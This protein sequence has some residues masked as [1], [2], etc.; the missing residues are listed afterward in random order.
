MNPL[1]QFTKN[2]ILERIALGKSSF[3]DEFILEAINNYNIEGSTKLRAQKFI[4][5]LIPIWTEY[6]KGIF[7]DLF[8]E[9]INLEFSLEAFTI[10][11]AS[12]INH[13][14]QEFLLGY[15]ILMSCCCIKKDYDFKNGRR[16]SHST[17]GE[18][19][20][21]WMAA[22]LF[23]DVGYDI[24]KAP[25]EE[26]YREKRNEFW[27][28]MTKREINT[29][30]LTFNPK[31]D[32]KKI[33]ENHIIKEFNKILGVTEY[34]LDNFENLFIRSVENRETWNRYDHG[35]ISAI[36]YLMELKKLQ[37]KYYNRNY[38]EWTPNKHA[39]LAM[40]LHNFR[41]KNCDLRL[42]YENRTTFIA[43]LLIICDEI[44]EWERERVD[45]DA[46]LPE[47]IK[48]QENGKKKTELIA[49]TFKDSHAYIVLN[50]KLKDSSYKEKFEEYLAEKIIL[51]KKHYPIQIIPIQFR[52][53]LKNKKVIEKDIKKRKQKWNEINNTNCEKKLL[54]PSKSKAIYEVYV[55][56]RIESVPYYIY[57]FPF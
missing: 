26:K 57:K 22:T 29:Y 56:H 27:D 28:F 43:Y 44:Q 37:E 52:K 25:E 47:E 9:Y 34:T 1:F 23:H 18:L 38:L 49:I 30:S 2:E 12:H 21:S 15:N 31:S 53:I 17:F 55:E 4:E 33:I 10:K 35:I 20:F 48:S 36:K 40:A 16:Y 14:I 45:I 42:T 7:V 32:I 41:Y 24:E 51:L 50:H 3:Y 8:R 13:V 6:K 5:A 19:L 11:H 39:I 54:I 46:E